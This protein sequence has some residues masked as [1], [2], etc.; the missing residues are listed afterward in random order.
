MV[1]A[2]GMYGKYPTP[3]RFTGWFNGNSYSLTCQRLMHSGRGGALRACCRICRHSPVID[4]LPAGAKGAA[5][6][7]HGSGRTA[8]ASRER[9]GGHPP[10]STPSSSSFVLAGAAGA[11]ARPHGSG[12][13]EAAGGTLRACRRGRSRRGSAGSPEPPAP[14]RDGGG[15]CRSSSKGGGARGEKRGP[16]LQQQ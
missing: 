11:A 14:V 10:Y 12:W 2:Y 3:F 6:R 13:A 5:A 1:R 16:V 8:A 15:Q 9:I 7:P 4:P